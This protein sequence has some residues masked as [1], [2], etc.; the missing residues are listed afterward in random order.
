MVAFA[1]DQI[2]RI[3]ARVPH[4]LAQVRLPVSKGRPFASDMPPILDAQNFWRSL[5]SD[6]EIHVQAHTLKSEEEEVSKR[7]G[8]CTLCSVAAVR[9]MAG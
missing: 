7:Q 8:G 4:H 2:F 1:R 3:A 6:K 5:P 9:K